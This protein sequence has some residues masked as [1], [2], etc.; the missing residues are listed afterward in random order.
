MLSRST[1]TESLPVLPASSVQV[2]V[3]VFVPAASGR[4][5]PEAKLQLGEASTLSVT[6]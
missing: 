5:S 2:T 1:V 3:I 4:L 6:V